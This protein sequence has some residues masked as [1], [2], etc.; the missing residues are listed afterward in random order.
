MIH[1]ENTYGEWFKYRV[2]AGGT[3]EGSSSF[4]PVWTESGF[5]TLDEIRAYFQG[6]GDMVEIGN[7]TVTTEQPKQYSLGNVMSIEEAS[8]P[9]HK[10]YCSWDKVYR[11]G[12]SCGGL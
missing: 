1:F 7:S 3:I 9:L 8:T 2:T 4:A 10:C 11:E 12:C 5:K 6:V